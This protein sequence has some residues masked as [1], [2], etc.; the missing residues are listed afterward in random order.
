MRVNLVYHSPCQ[1]IRICKFEERKKKKK[2]KNT[3]ITLNWLGESP[4]PQSYLVRNEALD[5]ES[6]TGGEAEGSLVVDGDGGGCVSG[7]GCVC[8]HGR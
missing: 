4:S 5:A 2:K 7:R 8:E 6:Q 3:C 1:L